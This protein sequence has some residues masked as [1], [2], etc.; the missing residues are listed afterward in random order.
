MQAAYGVGVPA[1]GGAKGE[2]TSEAVLGGEGASA[3]GVSGAL[4]VDGG[5]ERLEVVWGKDGLG[6]VEGMGGTECSCRA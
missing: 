2:G 3:G 6:M 5:E 4:R 1:L